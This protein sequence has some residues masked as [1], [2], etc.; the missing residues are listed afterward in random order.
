MRRVDAQDI[1]A[2]GSEQACGG[3]PG[4]DAGEVQHPEARQR[5]EWIP[6][7]FQRRASAASVGPPGRSGDADPGPG[8]GR[9]MHRRRKPFRARADGSSRTVVRGDGFLRVEGS[10]AQQGLINVPWRGGGERRHEPGGVVRI[11]GMHADPAV[12][13]PAEP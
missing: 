12:R 10:H 6:R 9:R 8:T 4:D 7:R 13:G 3:G 2:E 11:V 5:T 1:R